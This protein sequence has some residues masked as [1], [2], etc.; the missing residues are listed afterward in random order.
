MIIAIILS[1]APFAFTAATHAPRIFSLIAT[2]VATTV[3]GTSASRSTPATITT[4][5]SVSS[6][7]A[8]AT[9]L[10]AILAALEL[11]LDTVV[12]VGA[13]VAPPSRCLGPLMLAVVEAAIPYMPTITTYL[14]L[15]PSDS[16]IVTEAIIAVTYFVVNAILDARAKDVAM[17]PDV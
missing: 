2:H 13:I 12:E 17:V 1:R 14:I 16:L 11:A 9:T 3:I 4:P 8:T 15:G 10:A 7:V 6:I 5:H